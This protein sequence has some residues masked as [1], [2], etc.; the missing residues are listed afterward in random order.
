MSTHTGRPRARCD[1]VPP[2]LLERV[3]AQHPDDD[4]CECCR[5]TLM[6][7]AELRERRHL[8]ALTGRTEAVAP[9]AF[10]DG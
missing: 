6:L 4:V 8:V 1:F 9:P 3:A 5:G 10:V 7:D 2:Y